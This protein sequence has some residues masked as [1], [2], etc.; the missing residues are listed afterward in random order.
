MTKNNLPNVWS[1]TKPDDIP[2]GDMWINPNSNGNP[3]IRKNGK[4]EEINPFED[5][6][7]SKVK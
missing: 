7:E 2:D 5:L 3:K 6:E 1:K 4:W